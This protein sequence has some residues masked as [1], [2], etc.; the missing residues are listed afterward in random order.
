MKSLA[1]LFERSISDKD[2]AQEWYEAHVKIE[3][4]KKGSILQNKG[5]EK[6]NTFFVRNGLLR[7]YALDIQKK[8][9]IYMFAPEGWIVGD[10]EAQ[11]FNTP[12][13]LYVDCLEDSEVEVI[14]QALFSEYLKLIPEAN[15]Y[16][17]ILRL[18]RRIAV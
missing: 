6:A 2:K 13:A 5:D 12:A 9:R 8:E 16:D 17:E 11:A 7:S 1:E 3:T 10:M 15:L 14:D 18:V 4:Y